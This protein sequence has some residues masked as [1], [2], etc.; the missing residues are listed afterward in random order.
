MYFSTFCATVFYR[1]PSLLLGATGV[2][3]CVATGHTEFPR[4]LR[5]ILADI[6]LRSALLFN[7]GLP[8]APS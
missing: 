5:T 7:D 6:F 1:K 2:D 8:S 3:D 4:R